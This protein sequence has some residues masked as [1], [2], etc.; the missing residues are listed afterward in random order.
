M[1]VQKLNDT[2][3]PS[4]Q[5]QPVKRPY[6]APELLSWGTMRDITLKVGISGAS[7]GAMKS[8]NRTN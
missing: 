8:P 7:D 2:L 5:P 3:G 1:A 6:V 4:G